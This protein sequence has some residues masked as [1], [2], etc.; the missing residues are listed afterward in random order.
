MQ[1]K[2]MN[3]DTNHDL[4][5]QPYLSGVTLIKPKDGPIIFP[6][7]GSLFAM[8]LIIYF[9][10]FDAKYVDANYF[11]CFTNIPGNHGY[12][13]DNDLKGIPLSTLFKK[14]TVEFLTII[15][16]IY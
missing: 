8:P 3:F 5:V 16:I 1:K 9:V 6:S 2:E 11:T 4:I 15:I 14:E 13:S 12:Y 10:G 7:I